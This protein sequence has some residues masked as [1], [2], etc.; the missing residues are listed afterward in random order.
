[1]IVGDIVY[2]RQEPG[3]WRVVEVKNSG[4]VVVRNVATR[5]RLL[6]HR[7]DTAIPS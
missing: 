6:V 4:Y 2:I 1:M 7:N 3:L 5:V